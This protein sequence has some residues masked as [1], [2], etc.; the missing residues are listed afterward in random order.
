MQEG[1]PLGIIVHVINSA[2]FS[3]IEGQQSRAFV[4]ICTDTIVLTGYTERENENEKRRPCELGLSTLT[5][6]NLH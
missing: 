2:F 6:V 4:P 5:Y 3:G 1:W